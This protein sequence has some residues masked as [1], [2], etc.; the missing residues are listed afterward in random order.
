MVLWSD[1]LKVRPKFTIITRLLPPD[2]FNPEKYSRRQL[3]FPP[4]PTKSDHR[5]YP[6]TQPDING[7][8]KLCINPGV[9]TNLKI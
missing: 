3:I 9:L 7:H 4:Q 8:V 6:V 1:R 2:T 5:M